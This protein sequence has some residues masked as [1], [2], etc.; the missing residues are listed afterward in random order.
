MSAIHSIEAEGTYAPPQV[1]RVVIRTVA[2]LERAPRYR[3]GTYNLINAKLL[4]AELQGADLR[5]ADLYGADFTDADL[6]GADLTGAD[7]TGAILAETKFDGAV[8]S[9]TDISKAFIGG[10]KFQGSNISESIGVPLSTDISDTVFDEKDLH[11][12]AG[13]MGVKVMRYSWGGFSLG[14]G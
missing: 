12:M 13:R 7:L 11:E 8:L 9:G 2:D 3:D 10:A 4:K 1:A 14:R 6:R 5:G